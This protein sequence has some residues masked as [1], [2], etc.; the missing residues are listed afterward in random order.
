M[1]RKSLSLWRYPLQGT[2]NNTETGTMD[3]DLFSY[4]RPPISSAT[5]PTESLS[6]EEVYRR[7][8][9]DRTLQEHTDSVR[10]S[11]LTD[12]EDKYREEKKRLLPSVTFGGVFDY[13]HRDPQRLQEDKRKELEREKDP[14]K[15]SRLERD[16]QTLEGKRGLL[17]LSGYVTIDIDHISQTGLSLEELRDK[18][19]RDRGT[20]VRLIFVS[21][22]GDGLKL[23]CKSAREIQTPSQYKEVYQALRHYINSGYSGETEI[24]DSSGNDVTRLCLLPFDSQAILKDW[25]ETFHPELHPVPTH[26]QEPPEEDYSRL[27]Q[28]W[29]DSQDGIE[30]IVRR[31]EESG[32]DI[33]PEYSEYLPLV[34]SFTSLGDRG[35]PLLHRVCRLSPKYNQENTDRDWEECSKSPETQDIGYFVN[36]CKRRGIDVSRHRETPQRD[37]TSTRTKKASQKAGKDP[38]TSKEGK[39]REYLNIQDL[40]EIASQ[41][42]EGIST[43]Y[44]FQD[45]DGKKRERLVIP[46]GALTLVCGRSSHGKTR[47]LQNLALQIAS[48]EVES[49]GDGVVLYFSFE[50][51]LLDAVIRFSNIQVNIPQ[52]SQY[53]TSNTEV[54]LD[55]YKTGR[56]NKA[57]E[58]TRTRVLPRL[59]SF[60]ENLYKS[61]RLR[62]YYTPDLHSQ[63]LC[64]LLKYLSS[65]MKLKAVFL[66]YVQA[67]YKEGN[68][69]DRREE[70]REICKDLNDTAISLDIPVILS[71]QLNREAPNPTQMSGDNIAES[72][73]ITRY[74]NTILL[75]W[76]SARTRD[77]SLPGL[78]F[79]LNT[80][81]GKA[82][83]KRGFNL[84]V[85]GQLYAVLAKNRGGTPDLESFLEVVPETGKVVENAKEEIEDLPLE[86][87][88]TPGFTDLED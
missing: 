1:W 51:S 19:S 2:E 79:Y 27:L 18:L 9:T 38:S 50:E 23:V 13:R 73:D 22:S 8:T 72:A 25:G 52:L 56:L 81:D 29:E 61:G 31:V 14:Q 88:Q 65:Q 15:A 4:Y 82:L 30:E 35:L 67:I 17:S 12:G 68:R 47:L 44:E 21:P 60:E 24:V 3:K 84:G 86:Y 40:R 41:K 59:S 58:S 28:E 45:K 63:E 5:L 36:L 33:A 66:D 70:L 34:Y 87:S 7:I 75:L 42:K 43:L 26:R 74:A 53:G 78:A 11:L 48:R 62:I 76:D 37:S 80:E 16:I 49:G 32:V 6:L 83:Q 57:P 85:P 46:T 64:G 10:N 71:A 55:Y 20:G 77:I 39:F 69:K 54:L